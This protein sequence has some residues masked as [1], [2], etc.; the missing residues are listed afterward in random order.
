LA[1]THG[2]TSGTTYRFKISATNLYG[3]S[4]F[5]EETRAALGELPYKPDPPTKVELKSTITSIAV[6]WP[7]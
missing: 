6:E 2:L 1:T 4:E 7:K 5:S 3:D